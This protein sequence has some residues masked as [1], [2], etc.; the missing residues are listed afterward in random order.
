MGQELAR[1]GDEMER[2][3]STHLIDIDD[4]M[5]LRHIQQEQQRG[6]PFRKAVFM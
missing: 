4:V 6:K 1:I 3:Y 2:R 5:Q